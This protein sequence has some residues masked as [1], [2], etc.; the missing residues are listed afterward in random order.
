MSMTIEDLTNELKSRNINVSHQRLKV[1]EF[2]YKNQDHPTAY[3]IYKSLH[4]EIHTLSKTTVYNTLNTL[5]DAKLVRPINIDESN[6]RYDINTYNHGHF[7]CESCQNIT[8]FE[9]NSEHIN[10]PS[11]KDYNIINQELYIKG[12]CPD[13]SS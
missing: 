1:L 13:C 2:L 10:I 7:R 8:D 3:D 9:I 4:K 11:L 6:T 5:V 12:F